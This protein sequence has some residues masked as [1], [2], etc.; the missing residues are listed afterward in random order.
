MLKGMTGALA[1]LLA[2]GWAADAA[3]QDGMITAK[4]RR[5]QCE[6][7]GEIQADGSGSS[8]TDID[9][10]STLGLS[11]K[12]N[13]NEIGIQLQLPI[14]IIGRMSLTRWTGT[15]EDTETLSQTITYGGQTFSGGTTVDSEF[16]ITATT[17]LMHFGMSTPKVAGTGVAAGAALGVKFFEFE[18]SLSG[19][20]VSESAKAAGPIPVLGLFTKTAL[21]AYLFLEVEV[22]GLMVPGFLSGG[23]SG[24][25]WEGNAS[26]VFR[27]NRF[28]AGIGYKIFNFTLEDD[29]GTG[30]GDVEV[31]LKMS[32]MAFEVG[33]GF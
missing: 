17:L 32:G 3:A 26:V 30:V 11:D 29:S 4:F 27:Y 7:S 13:F 28:F 25:I 19:S 1:A 21:L 24:A 23:L 15:F 18:G 16:D 12:E 33:M 14:P 31:D 22:H 10:D 9:V 5:W 2:L 6:L 8:G 20:G